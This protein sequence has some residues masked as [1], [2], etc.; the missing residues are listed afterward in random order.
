MSR[1]TASFDSTLSLYQK[2]FCHAGRRQSPSR[3][4]RSVGR[5][6]LRFADPRFT[7]RRKLRSAE[8]RFAKALIL[9]SQGIGRQG[10]RKDASL[11]DFQIAALLQIILLSNIITQY[12]EA[13]LQALSSMI[14]TSLF[15][16]QESASALTKM[17]AARAFNRARR[18]GRSPEIA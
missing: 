10:A 2:D 9:P 6:L 1:A 18:R 3:P 15:C 17:A 5:A 12:F 8:L 11:H 14:R 16:F 7:L 13:L 4:R